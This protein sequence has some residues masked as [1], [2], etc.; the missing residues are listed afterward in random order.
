M[1]TVYSKAACVQCAMTRRALDARGIAYQLVDLDDDQET[2]DRLRAIGMMQAPVVIA[3][4]DA[5]CG[6]RPD[7]IAAIEVGL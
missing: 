2:I 7:K 3:E 5:W 4:G 6:F 1:M